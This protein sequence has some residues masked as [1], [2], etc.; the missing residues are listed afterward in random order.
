MSET[1]S[2]DELYQQ[3]VHWGEITEESDHVI[4]DVSEDIQRSMLPNCLDNYP[5][6]DNYV[7]V[8]EISLPGLDPLVMHAIDLHKWM[9]SMTEAIELVQSSKNKI[10]TEVP[11]IPPMPNV[12]VKH[13]P[14]TM[15]FIPLDEQ[16]EKEELNVPELSETV[17]KQIL[18][19][20]T[21]AMM[22]QI[23][24]QKSHQSVL[25]ILVDVLEQ[26][27]IKF[28][29]RLILALHEEEDIGTGGFPNVL[30]RV[31][32]ETGFG[33]AKGI[34]NYYQSRVIKY[35]NVLYQRCVEL[36]KYYSSLV[37]SRPLSPSAEF[38]SLYKVKVKEEMESDTEIST[39]V[40][41]L[42][43][44]GYQLLESLETEVDESQGPPQTIED[45]VMYSS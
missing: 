12:Q 37:N 5:D 29:N 1:E 3:T 7:Q 22:A 25:D 18:T 43:T 19:K 9:S 36:E 41:D 15:N 38:G 30:E 8:Q 6:N 4:P 13:K 17:L 26:F 28:C 2:E 21:A 10:L 45:A 42:I 24:F 35:I 34:H 32:V 40:N 31:L 14:N 39:S 44:T 23:G 27:Y 16:S 11:K 33:G 20:C